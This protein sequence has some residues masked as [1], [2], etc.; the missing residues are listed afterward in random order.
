MLTNVCRCIFE[1]QQ[2]IRN[3]AETNF[4][5]FFMLF[6][7]ILINCLEFLLSQAVSSVVNEIINNCF[8]LKLMNTLWNTWKKMY[9]Y[10]EKKNI[11]IYIYVC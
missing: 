3:G 2:E 7:W 10:I 9:V 6:F 5:A 1:S 11:Y 8:V 4:S